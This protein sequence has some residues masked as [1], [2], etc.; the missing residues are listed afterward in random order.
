MFQDEADYR[1]QEAGEPNDDGALIGLYLAI[2][3]SLSD[4]KEI[5]HSNCEYFLIIR[6]LKDKYVCEKDLKP[7][8]DCHIHSDLLE[9]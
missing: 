3:C 7:F 9:G 1:G 4:W 5:E 2:C 6:N 8:T